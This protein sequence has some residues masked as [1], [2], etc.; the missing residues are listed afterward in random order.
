MSRADT[1]E[2]TCFMELAE[3][4]IP[5]VPASNNSFVGRRE[6]VAKYLTRMIDGKPGLILDPKCDLDLR[7]RVTSTVRTY[8]Y[9]GFRYVLKV[10]ECR[11]RMCP[12]VGLRTI[13]LPLWISDGT[14][15]RLLGGRQVI[16]M[17][18]A[19]VSAIANSETIA[20]QTAT[21]LPVGAWQTNDVIRV[22][23]TV[24][25]SGTT[26]SLTS[27]LR[28]GTA[29]TTAD[30]AVVSATTL[31]AAANRSGTFQYDIKLVSATSAQRVGVATTA[32]VSATAETAAVTISSAATAALFVSF[33]VLSSSTNDTVGVTSAQIELE[34]NCIVHFSS[35][36]SE[37]R[38]K[39]MQYYYGQPYG[40]EV[41][42]RSQVVTTEVKDAVEG[43][44][45]P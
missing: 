1:D 20:L 31:L 9:K 28:I 40:N 29:G 36:L 34:A 11:L 26:D 33:T 45:P 18:G 16:A 12:P 10:Q 30:T 19:A 22:S 25:K 21:A 8:Q 38:R 6:A 24:N 5:A 7:T 23:F 37:Q 3:E 32:Q 44:L 13:V 15:W 2:K 42:G 41:E 4:G 17:L 35:M 43:I 14:R 27:S 39:A